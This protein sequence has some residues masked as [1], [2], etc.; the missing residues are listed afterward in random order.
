MWVCPNRSSFI[1]VVMLGVLMASGCSSH[2]V[3]TGANSEGDEMASSEDGNT[4]DSNGKM[5]QANGPV[6]VSGR[7]DGLVNGTNP[8]SNPETM[9]GAEQTF[10]Q[11]SSNYGRQ[12]SGVDGSGPN[13]GSV[14]GFENGMAASQNPDPEAWANAYLGNGKNSREFY[15]DPSKSGE[16]NNTLL[17]A[18]VNPAAWAESYRKENGGP[19]PEYVDPDSNIQRGR[20]SSVGIGRTDSNGTIFESNFSGSIGIQHGQVQDIYFAFD[21]WNIS[22]SAA[23]HLEE[24]AQWLQSNP[25]KALT[26]EGHCDQRGTQDYNLVLG[27]KRADAAREYLVNLG[28]QPDR[29]KIVSYGKE[30][31]FCQNDSEDCFQ[32]NRRNHMV[33]RVN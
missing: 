26:I 27:Q 15:G 20:A 13:H 21:S 12:Y 5:S 31:P 18:G 4:V 11:G 25:G 29:I 10:G 22:N 17:Q 33:V 3:R 6:G 19:S 7:N 30:R 23:K 9:G 2:S 16:P 14:S 32:E 28:V 1:V 8:N 24:G